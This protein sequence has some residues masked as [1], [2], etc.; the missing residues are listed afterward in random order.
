MNIID[1]NLF[2]ER[3]TIEDI[4]NVYAPEKKNVGQ[5]IQ[6]LCPNPEHNDEHLGSCY[7]IRGKSTWRCDGCGASG[8]VLSLASYYTNIPTSRLQE[9]MREVCNVLHISE[10][11]VSLKGNFKRVSPKRNLL[12]ETEYKRLCGTA[13]IHEEGDDGKPKITYLRTLAITDAKR[14]NAFVIAKSREIWAKKIALFLGNTQ[15]LE[16]IFKFFQLKKI[17]DAFSSPKHFL[18]ITMKE[19]SELLKRAV[20]EKEFKQEREIRNR[21]FRTFKE[22]KESQ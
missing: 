22:T 12:N 18:E 7:Y 16:K 6:F 15:E 19:E 3:V 9:L 20:G 13:Y 2:K 17:S 10:E 14:H 8:D 1:K 11:E 21:I 4:V 5:S